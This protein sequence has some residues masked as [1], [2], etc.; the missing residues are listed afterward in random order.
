MNMKR[1]NADLIATARSFLFVPANRPDRFSKALNSAA[2]VV[3]LDL[4][5]SVPPEDKVLAR[6]AI[7]REWA[8]LC[9]H[10][11]QVVIRI[12]APYTSV[13]HDDLCWLANLRPSPAV[14]VSKTDSASTLQRVIESVP[15]ALLL[16]LIESA[17]GYVRLEEIAATANVVRLVVGHIDFSVDTG[18]ICSDEQREID[19]LRF[20]VAVQSKVHH[21]ASPVDGVTV[22]IENE[23]ILRDETQRALRFGFGAKL[24]IHPRQVEVVHSA[25]APN[26]EELEW[27]QNVFRLSQEA[28]GAAFKFDG[29]MVDAPV[30]LQAQRILERQLR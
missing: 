10:G 2:D 11:K 17:E 19:A 6:R 30:V 26:N 29:R 23:K 3:I 8:D 28:S 7:S 4:E 13:G 20:S 5:D 22:D 25:L 12:N 15:T 1:L 24:C 9:A 14:M 16:P 18:I 27:A 21:L